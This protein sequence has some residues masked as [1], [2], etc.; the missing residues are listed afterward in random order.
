MPFL[1]LFHIVAYADSQEVSVASIEGLNV[2]Y[3]L[4]SVEV[5]TQPAKCTY[6]GSEHTLSI[7]ATATE[8]TNFRYRWYY[9]SS[10]TEFVQL[11]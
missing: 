3:S 1:H 4:D 5:T 6:D 11:S 7:N 9:S 8:A 10:G 2:T